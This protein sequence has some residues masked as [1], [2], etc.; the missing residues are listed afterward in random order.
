MTACDQAC[1]IELFRG[2]LHRVERRRR[3]RLALHAARCTRCAGLTCS[4]G[5]GTA[6]GP[7]TR[8]TT[9]ARRGPEA[10]R[11]VP[12]ADE[13]ISLERPLEIVAR[14]RTDVSRGGNEA[15]AIEDLA[16]LLRGVI[17]VAEGG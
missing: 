2:A 3:S 16:D 11:R 4:G 10:N 5:R 17:V 7:G 6:C 12:V 13:L 15:G 9:G 1:F 14:G 8:R